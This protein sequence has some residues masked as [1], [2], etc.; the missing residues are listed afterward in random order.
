[1][2]GMIRKARLADYLRQGPLYLGN[3][4]GMT[5]RQTTALCVNP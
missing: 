1:M 2:S 3:F 5:L 4:L